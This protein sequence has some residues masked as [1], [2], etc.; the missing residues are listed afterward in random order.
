M[1]FRI[2]NIIFPL[3]YD[4]PFVAKK[5]GYFDSLVVAELYIV[6][7]VSFLQTFQVVIVTADIAISKSGI[8]C[9]TMYSLRN[10]PLWIER[11]FGWSPDLLLFGQIWF[12]QFGQDVFVYAESERFKV[13]VPDV[14]GFDHAYGF[15]LFV[16]FYLQYGFRL[17]VELRADVTT[18]MFIILVLMQDS[19]DMDLFV[20]RPLHEFR[21]N[22]GRFT[23]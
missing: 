4:H 5:G 10:L 17:V 16:H 14:H 1:A 2:E 20:V 21:D 15:V 19:M 11:F 22:F 12:Y 6:Q 3:L 7:S 8:H 23:G 9:S 13:P 18:R